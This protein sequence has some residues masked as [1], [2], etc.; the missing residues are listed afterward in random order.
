[1]KSLSRSR[2]RAS[3]VLALA[4]LVGASAVLLAMLMLTATACGS[5]TGN[6]TVNVPDAIRTQLEKGVPNDKFA[7]YLLASTPS[8]TWSQ[9]NSRGLLVICDNYPPLV[10]D[11]VKSTLG[12]FAPGTVATFK[13]GTTAVDLNIEVP[14][15]SSLSGRLDWAVNDEMP[16]SPGLI[17]LTERAA[18]SALGDKLVEVSFK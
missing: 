12:S 15:G 6:H 17:L 18:A 13:K 5:S 7:F 10:S 2:S 14:V 9:L 3:V 1:M 8:V 16:K 4:L 11:K